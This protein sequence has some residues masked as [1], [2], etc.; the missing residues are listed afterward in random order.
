MRIKITCCRE[1]EERFTGCHTM[2]IDYQNQK[3]EIEK[4]KEKIR[5]IKEIENGLSERKRK[6]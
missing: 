6:R 5:K 4:N 3:K 1:C 2:C